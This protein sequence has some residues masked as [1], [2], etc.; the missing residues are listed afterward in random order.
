MA[1][2]NHMQ[3]LLQNKTGKI[4]FIW[5]LFNLLNL[6]DNDS[7]KLVMVLNLQTM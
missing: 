3:R 5:N 7:S 4:G 6:V 2:K 1:I